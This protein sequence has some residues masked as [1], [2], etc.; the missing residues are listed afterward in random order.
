[1][2]AMAAG[3]RQPAATIRDRLQPAARGPARPLPT[4]PTVNQIFVFLGIESWKPVL[5]ALLLPPVPFLLLALLGARL[6][7]P[8]R[9]LGWTMIALAVS[10]L[11]LSATNGAER[12][13]SLHLL[14]P[15]P[16]M[17]ADRIAELKEQ[18]RGKADTAIVVLGAGVQPYAPEYGVSNLS[19]ESV[20][21]LRYGLW[22][23]RETGLPVAFS[24]GIGW[25]GADGPTEAQ[26]AARI[27]TQEFGRPL[28][29]LEER[30]R[31]TRENAALST[32]LLR[33][34][35]V[36]HVV[37]VTHGSHMPRARRAFEKV[38]G[39]GMRIEVAP[40][41]LARQVDDPVLLWLPTASGFRNVRQVLHELV[42]LGFGA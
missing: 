32:K 39:D 9:G 41:G 14:R 6:L 25:A 13:L 34:A 31:D 40:M 5:T 21:R 37:V 12:F 2:V 1:M 17:H 36:R 10:M 33:E 15:P 8:R 42:G 22:L 4:P 35:G 27:A 3:A 20:E 19:P 28:K 18:A 24:G 11:W 38:A 16:A 29:W 23:G 26:T 30:S 7:L